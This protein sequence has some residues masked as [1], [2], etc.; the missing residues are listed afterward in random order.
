VRGVGEQRKASGKDTAD[1]LH[2]H[3]AANQDERHDQAL[4]AG[5]PQVVGVVMAA[6]AVVVMP[7]AAV[8]VIVS[9][10]VMAVVIMVVVV[11]VCV[12][13]CVIMVIVGVVMLV[14]MAVVVLVGMVMF[15]IVGI[16]GVVVV[17]VLVGMVT[18]VIVAVF[19]RHDGPLPCNGRCPAGH[20]LAGHPTCDSFAFYE[21]VTPSAS[22]SGVC[23][24][25]GVILCRAVLTAVLV[26]VDVAVL[27]H[28]LRAH[29]GLAG[30]VAVGVAVASAVLVAVGV[31]VAVAMLAGM[32]MTMLVVVV[33]VVMRGHTFL[34][35]KLL[36]FCVTDTVEPY[37]SETSTVNPVWM[38]DTRYII[39]KILSHSF[40]CSLPE[41]NPA[42][43][44]P[45]LQIGDTQSHK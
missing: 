31:T 25:V 23:N 18:L 7:M 24:V 14:V 15:V 5:A 43:V 26:A 38:I 32:L 30:R 41:T 3:E 4:L 22:L 2:K 10:V 27:V 42:P 35:A 17:V 20:R 33:T 19:S 12:C 36:S 9:R 6:V 21:G 8:P 29:D 40:P 1:D 28:V 13:V 16:V 44:P 45:F 11:C 34:L 37:L 39:I